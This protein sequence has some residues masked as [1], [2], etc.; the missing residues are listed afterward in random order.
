MP[1]RP[2]SSTTSWWSC[3]ASPTSSGRARLIFSASRSENQYIAKLKRP[4]TTAKSRMPPDPPKTGGFPDNHP[5]RTLDGWIYVSNSEMFAPRT[6]KAAD[7]A[8]I[9]LTGFSSHVS[10]TTL[11]RVSGRAAVISPRSG[12]LEK[13]GMETPA[14]VNL[15]FTMRTMPNTWADNNGNFTFEQ[16]EKRQIYEVSAAATKPLAD[17][18]DKRELRMAVLASVDGVS[19]MVL[20]NQA[21]LVMV[22]DTVKWLMGDE[23][24]V[25]DVVQESDA[26]IVHTNA[27]DK[28]WF[29][30]TIFA[31]PILILV[32]G[33]L[34]SRRGRRRAS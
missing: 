9:A 18:K 25:A 33:L 8:N 5:F 12:W 21:N 24:I 2:E 7:H 13:I 32:G 29:Y 28:L 26:P 34:Y 27:Q 6:H 16:G 22:L 17:S 30:S 23:A 10:V 20:R 14:G 4:A 31:A 15:D 11:S 3:G 1:A 19:D